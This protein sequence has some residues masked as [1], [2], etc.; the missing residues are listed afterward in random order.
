MLYVV[1][2]EDRFYS[3]YWFEPE[4]P[5]NLNLNPLDYNLFDKDVVTIPINSS[6]VLVESPVR[7]NQNI[8]A[9]LDLA[10][11]K[12]Y[13]KLK[14]VPLRKCV[15]NDKHLPVFLVPYK[16]KH[17]GFSKVQAN[18]YVTVRFQSWATSVRPIAV[19][20]QTIGPVNE[21]PNYYEYQ[22]YCKQLHISMSKFSTA[23]AKALKPYSDNEALISAIVAKY[24]SIVD[25][26]HYP[27]IFTVDPEHSRDFDDAFG[28]I[29][30]SND[31]TTTAQLTLSIYIANVP[32]WLDFLNLWADVSERT[33][34]IYLPPDAS[35][36]PML[37]PILSDVLCSLQANQRRIA[38]TM[39]IHLTKQQSTSIA[40]TSQWTIANVTFCNTVICVK[41]NYVYEA[42]ELLANSEYQL[43]A[44][45]ATQLTKS[46][47][48]INDSHDVVSSLM[49]LMNTWCAKDLQSFGNGVFRSVTTSSDLTDL[50]LVP[51]E[52]QHFRQKI[53][54]Q[55][56]TDI[57][58][59]RHELMQLDAYAHITSPIRRLVDVLNM[60]QM[61]QNLQ[62]LSLS[63]GAAAFL[64]NR[65]HK[66][67]CINECTRAARHLQND[68][69]LL[70]LCTTDK[71]IVDRIFDGYIVNLDVAQAQVQVYLPDIKMAAKCVTNLEHLFSLY[72]VVKCKL[73]VFDD[74]SNLHRK[75]R[76]QLI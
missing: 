37:P 54:S 52:V 30:S 60:L 36:K 2:I 22:L 51:K 18:L 41:H 48:D 72:D 3:K 56:T 75:I 70:H 6:P 69:A 12:I 44:T 63:E 13:G 53:V 61:Q 45:V 19:V 43:L 40:N 34:T 50:P 9:I 65:L 57:T 5:L 16:V 29:E 28:I 24:P 47:S 14:D 32:V 39:D 1:H 25:R 49:I 8:P 59:T 35:K 42:P 4:L 58:A 66:I 31:D 46:N 38:F 7:M 21:L 74:E 15:P 67:G 27:N 55:Y 73:F 11:N 62:L 33:S 64:E 71:T 26:T 76:V 23:T 10:S 17:I 68:C 20:N